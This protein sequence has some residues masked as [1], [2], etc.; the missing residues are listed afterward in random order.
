MTND[1]SKVVVTTTDAQ[2]ESDVLAMNA[3]GM[4]IWKVGRE[5]RARQWTRR[6]WREV[7]PEEMRPW[8][9]APHFG[10][11]STTK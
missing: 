2:Y 7:K 9:G 10:S 6:N 11:N 8:E 1:G 5:D 4:F 3:D